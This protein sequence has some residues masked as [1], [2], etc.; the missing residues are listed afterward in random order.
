M[1]RDVPH[2][3]R[4]G[5]RARTGSWLA[6][7]ALL[8]LSGV[9]AIA[10]TAYCIARRL[11]FPNELEWMEGLFVEHGQHVLA[12][13][14]TY[15]TPSADFLPLIYTPLF[16][17]LTAFMMWLGAPGFLSGR[18]AALACLLLATAIVTLVSARALRRRVLA[19]LTPSLIAA[20]Y[21]G[22]DCYYDVARAD[23][24]GL[25]FC[26]LLAA[27]MLIHNAPLSAII[28]GVVAAGAYFSKQSYAVYLVAFFAAMQWV[29]GREARYG[30]LLAAVLIGVS[31]AIAQ[32]TTSG[33]YWL[34]TVTI[35]SHQR[36]HWENL[37][38][39]LPSDFLLSFG[40]HT[41]VVAGVAAN[42]GLLH[43]R[44]GRGDPRALPRQRE[45]LPFRV[46]IVASG[47]AAVYAAASRASLG[48]AA[49]VMIP[50]VVFS[51]GLIPAA[52]ECV[53]D[54]LP[55][56]ELRGLAWRLTAIALSLILMRG[57][58]GFEG[59]IPSPIDEAQWRA[60]R[61]KLLRYGPRERIWVVDHA[62]AFGDE[63]PLVT[64]PHMMP[65][66][67]YL[68][69]LGVPT[70]LA[71]P[72]E[73]RDRIQKRYYCAIVARENDP[74]FERLIGDTYRPDRREPAFGLPEFCGAPVTAERI[75]I[76]RY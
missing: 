46:L 66:V 50:F 55:R 13:H 69:G 39:V 48:G 68:G 3:P 20:G 8:C 76:P 40:P 6:C 26:A 54:G 52:L 11:T 31:I 18:I 44:L 21:V 5:I 19:L 41:L 70:G 9:A 10:V 56:A 22:V 35:P 36:V 34:Y 42:L 71:L 43:A 27:A 7:L 72:K 63:P 23:A 1:S 28:A 38:S 58:A 15:P 29:R 12:G 57:L 67:D 16:H 64:H 61:E 75:W 49:N 25:F 51:A 4:F 37:L 2:T 74:G 32:Q 24:L 60:L 53:C 14:P 73:L 47:A 17:W 33:T 62:A 59:R 45:S 65:L 30:A